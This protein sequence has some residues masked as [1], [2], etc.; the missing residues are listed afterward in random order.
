MRLGV[1]E[2][3]ALHVAHGEIELRDG[4]HRPEARRRRHL[5]VAAATC[6]Q[7]RRQIAD[8]RVQ[9]AIDHCVHVFVARDRLCAGDKVVSYRGEP[10][11][12]P[13]GLIIRQYAAGSQSGR[14]RP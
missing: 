9:Q 4:V 7:L 13:R 8:V 5:I 11:V 2:K 1:L 12:H 10:G 3:N 14:P 6:V